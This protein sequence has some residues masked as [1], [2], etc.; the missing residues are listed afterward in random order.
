M[1]LKQIKKNG[2]S[3]VEGT[4]FKE[5]IRDPENEQYYGWAKNRVNT[6]TN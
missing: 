4:F 5:Q 6:G 2:I 3:N 1:L